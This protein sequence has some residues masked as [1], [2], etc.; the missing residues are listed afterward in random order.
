MQSLGELG[1]VDEVDEAEVAVPLPLPLAWFCVGS[2]SDGGE[3]GE[4]GWWG[5]QQRHSP[6]QRL[7]RYQPH[8]DYA[9]ERYRD[10]FVGTHGAVGGPTLVFLRD[11]S[12]PC[13]WPRNGRTMI[14]PL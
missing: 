7:P 1:I 9:H 10:R 13:A 11:H 14:Y 4:G 3:S 12:S 8:Q 2:W 6:P 5:Q